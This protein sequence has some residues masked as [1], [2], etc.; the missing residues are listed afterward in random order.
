MNAKRRYDFALQYV[1]Q[2]IEFWMDVIWSDESKFELLSSG[3]RK[4][5]WRKSVEEFKLKQ[6]QPTVKHGGGSLMIWGCFSYHGV[7]KLK[8]IKGIMKGVDYVAILEESSIQS[9]EILEQKE[10]FVFQQDKSY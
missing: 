7:G 5:T 8:F 2:P 6:L 3:K 10:T 1:Q 4:Y 9:A